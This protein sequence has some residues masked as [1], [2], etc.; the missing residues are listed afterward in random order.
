MKLLFG[1]ASWTRISTAMA[2]AIRNMMKLVT[3]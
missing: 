3:M 2:P 1:T